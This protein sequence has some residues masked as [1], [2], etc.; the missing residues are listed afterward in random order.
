MKFSFFF[1]NVKKIGKH[2]KL[3]IHRNAA[4][5]S[6]ERGNIFGCFFRLHFSD[7]IAGAVRPRTIFRLR[8]IV[9]QIEPGAYS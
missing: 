7:I 1:R 9:S 6:E 4:Q 2:A 5:G 3:G 8:A